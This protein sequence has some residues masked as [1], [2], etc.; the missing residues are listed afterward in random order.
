MDVTAVTNALR[1]QYPDI[2]LVSQRLVSTPRLFQQV[3]EAD[4]TDRQWMV[5]QVAY[6]GGYFNWPRDSTGEELADPLG[7]YAPNVLASPPTCRSE[8]V[9]DRVRGRRLRRRQS[10]YLVRG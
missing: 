1:Y 8:G 5:L 7:S 4:L 3:V 9:S 6:Y 2:E 10:L